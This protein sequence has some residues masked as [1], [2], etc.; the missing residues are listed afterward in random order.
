[1]AT[2][3]NF[4]L[5]EKQQEIFESEARFKV[6]AAGRRGGKTFF[7]AIVLIMEAL[8]NENHKGRSL[9][10]AHVWYVAPT[11]QQ[12]RDIMWKQLKEIARPVAKQIKEKDMTIVMPN[13]RYIVL[14]GADNEDTL[15]GVSLSYCVLDEFADMKPGVFDVIL[16]PALSDMVGGA[17]FIGTPKGKNH[18]YK[19]WVAAADP[20]NP[21]MQAFHFCSRD[22]PM[23]SEEEIEAARRTSS[24]EA[25]RQEFEASFSTG[26]GGVFKA[27]EFQYVDKVPLGHPGYTY[28]TVDPAGFKDVGGLSK[29]QVAALDETAIAI[30]H[31]GPDGWYVKDIQHGR[32][33]VRETSLRII[34]AA[35]VHHPV[36]LG[37]EGGA[38]KNAIMPYLEDQMQRLNIYPNVVELK[39]GGTKKT[40]RIIWALQGRFQHGKIKFV[41]GP[42]NKALEEQLLDFPDPLA[43]DDL[44]DA[45]AYIDQIASAVYSTHDIEVDDWEPLDAIAGY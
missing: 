42:W 26:G 20:A 40:D 31:V 4:A 5:H 38:L 32:W 12:A 11:Y 17:L 27:D 30:V 33:G 1:M 16:R 7:A 23:I 28:I 13:G 6:V 24:R 44:P 3:L 37:I 10:N 2:T 21:D 43:H 14:K 9:R 45:L 34:R 15:R 19:L 35:Q 29:A 39:H 36:A 25:F 18:F 22:N 41:K 8:K